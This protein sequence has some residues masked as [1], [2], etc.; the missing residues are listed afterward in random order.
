MVSALTSSDLAARS[1]SSRRTLA[2][3]RW[4][5]RWEPC[6]QL[7]DE[8]VGRFGLLPDSGPKTS[9]GPSPSTPA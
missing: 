8:S 9:L 1:A 4:G 7:G 3:A 5:Q 2:S 6:A